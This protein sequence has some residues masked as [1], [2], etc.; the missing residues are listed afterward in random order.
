MITEKDIKF[1]KKIE[2]RKKMQAEQ[3]PEEHKDA[4]A[5]HEAN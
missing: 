4:A 2:K 1:L 5:E 3:P